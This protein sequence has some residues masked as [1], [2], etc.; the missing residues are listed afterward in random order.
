MPVV[1]VGVRSLDRREV[2]GLLHAHDDAAGATGAALFEH[3]RDRGFGG[4]EGCLLVSEVAL[5]VVRRVVAIAA[6]D[7]DSGGWMPWVIG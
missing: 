3:E 2:H 5:R 6:E 7:E 4:G 1:D